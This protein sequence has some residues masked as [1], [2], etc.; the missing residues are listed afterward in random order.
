MCGIVAYVGHH[1]A[2][3][4]LIK[5]LQRLEYRGYDSAGV[6]MLSNGEINLYKKKGKVSDLLEFTKDKDVTGNIGIGHTRWAT[7]GPPNDVNAH[8]HFSENKKLAIIHN[9]IIENY[10]SLKAELIKRGH[11]FESET[12]T[13]VLIHLIEDIQE[14][15]GKDLFEAVRIA[16]GEVIGAYAIVILSKD[17]PHT[18]IAAKKSSPMVIGIGEDD[19]YIASDATPII[20][21]TKNVVYLEDEEIARI[22]LKD[23]LKLK[24]IKN[25]KIEPYIQELELQLEA[26]E[27]GGYDHFMLKE[28]YEQPRSVQD[29]MR[30]RLN[31][32][33]GTVALGGIKDYE[34]K[35]LNAN[36]IIIVACGTSWHAG[37]VGEYLFEDL[38]RIPV[39]V[40][41]A[42]EFRYRN[43]IINENDVVIAISQSG[44]TADTI[45]ALE[46]AKSKGATILGVCN[47][48]GSTISRITDAGVYTHAGPE[49]G[50]ASTKAFTAQ[51]TVLCLMALRLGHLKG[52]INE[53]DFHR[54][55]IELSSVPEKIENV[56]EN[57]E[58]IK[59]VSAKYKDVSNFLYL[60]RGY[61][62]P[63]AL[64]GALKLKEISY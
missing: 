19:F 27:K 40:E 28:I 16:L 49:I 18:L 14:K 22:D 53:S 64:E 56:L 30:G 24:T 29:C 6:A 62:F 45:A 4:I 10:A 8:P 54:L 33:K 2:F 23:G 46:L 20:E 15:T 13:E 38:A 37:L 26:I 34:N 43:P 60:G 11:H 3:P 55:L 39:E 59:E 7:H 25:E 50:V 1:D 48:V 47:V 52:V 5:G 17:D 44:E 9:G 32:R 35:I 57:A 12:D 63:V 42:S 31:I 41:Y 21:Y 61:N 58:Y 36:R 51:V